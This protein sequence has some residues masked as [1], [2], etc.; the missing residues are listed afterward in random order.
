MKL[1]DLKDHEDLTDMFLLHDVQLCSK[2]LVSNAVVM[3]VLP[4][5][6]LQV[7]QQTLG[8]HIYQD[9]LLHTFNS[10]YE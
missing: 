4:T 6:L 8:Q 3:R 7:L 9:Q 5:Q 10:P 1:P 2:H